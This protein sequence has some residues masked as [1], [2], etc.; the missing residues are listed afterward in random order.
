MPRSQKPTS[1]DLFKA[2]RQ[3]FS[4]PEAQVASELLFWSQF[5]EHEFR[6]RIGFFKEDRELA[7]KIGKHP[8]SIGRTLRKLGARV[9]EEMPDALFILD[10][11]PKPWARSGR[12][13]WLF[14]TPRGDELVIAAQE[15]A[16]AARSRRK[17]REQDAAIEGHQTNRPISAKGAHRSPQ[18][19]ATLI[20]QMN[21]SDL[22]TEVLSSEEGEKKTPFVKR[23][24]I[25]GRSN[26][27][28]K[29][30]GNCLQR[31]RS[32]DA[33]LATE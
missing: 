3:Y 23:K 15:L 20:E 12:V 2:C 27:A 13:R 33:H 19:A 18:T 17:K 26:K 25:S 31:M 29:V 14:R 30:V 32:G 21:C 24:K 7:D 28:Q 10:Y 9:G 16:A 11:G 5:A 6:G 22:P 8:K 4:E 1:S